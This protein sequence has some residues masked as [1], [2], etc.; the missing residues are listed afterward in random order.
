MAAQAGPPRTVEFAIANVM[1]RRRL[2]L[3][4]DQI[5]HAAQGRETRGIAD[6]SASG[7][8]LPYIFIE[9]R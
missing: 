9:T 3:V 1:P 6:W 7:P 4:T 5:V 2:A 8:S